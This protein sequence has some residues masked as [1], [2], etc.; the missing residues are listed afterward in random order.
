MLILGPS[1]DEYVITDVHDSRHALQITLHC[2][3]VIDSD[4]M[5]T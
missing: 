2:I 1:I 5:N 4:Y 3:I